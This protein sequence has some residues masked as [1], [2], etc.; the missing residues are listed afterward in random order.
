MAVGYQPLPHENRL[1]VEGEAHVD[2]ADGGGLE[3]ALKL[4]R[5]QVPHLFLARDPGRADDDDG[6][7]VKV[8]DIVVPTVH[9]LRLGPDGD[10]RPLRA[11][12]VRAEAVQGGRRNVHRRKGELR[13]HRDPLLVGVGVI[14][15]HPA[16]AEESTVKDKGVET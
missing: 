10:E 14:R 11:R 12:R 7:A 8:L 2:L 3:L 4:F 6:V 5:E 1:V 13:P 15:R 16:F 9:G